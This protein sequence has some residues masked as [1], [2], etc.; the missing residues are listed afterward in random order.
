[1][2][3]D[4]VIGIDSSTTATKAIAW[5]AKGRAVAETRANQ[6]MSNPKPGWF[7]QDVDNWTGALT[8]VLKQLTRKI[9][10]K[11]VAALAISNQRES[12]AQFDARGKTLRP[13]T[14][15]LDERAPAQAA[16]LA[17]KFG[18]E[19]LREISGKPADITP[20]IS[21]CAWFAENMPGLWKKTAMTAEVH[22]VLVHFLTGNWHTSTA[23]ADPMGLIDMARYDWSDELLAAVGLTRAQV[24][25]LFRP[26]EQVGKVTPEA[27]KLTGIKAG[28]PVIA[29]GGDGQCAGTGTNMF[30][31]GR[32]YVNIGTA[33]VSGSSGTTY[34]HAQAFRTLTAVAEEGYI[35]ETC[36]RTGTFLINW[37]VE[38]LFNVDPV[39]NPG[40]FRELER[41]AAAAPIGAGG[42]IVMP[43]WSGSMTPYWDSST[44]GVI[45][46][47][48][49]SHRRGDV[50]RAV[51]EGI[52]LEQ[53]LMTNLASRESQPI[54]HYVAI[55]GGSR[56]DLLCQMLADASARSVKRLDTVE[57]SSLGAA[58]AAAKGAGWFDSIPLAATAMAGKPVKTFRPNRKSSGRY[59]ELLAIYADLYPSVS[60][61]SARLTAFAEGG[62]A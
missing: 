2:P 8:K 59:Q 62:R 49:S 11:R 14:L 36:L 19:R 50:Y 1:M 54:D 4:L 39:K 48:T 13:G 23:S 57:A 56:S 42:I 53:A 15:W 46:G 28:T 47:L 44:R 10:A 61:W 43:H 31:K 30:A 41:E 37:V 35:F 12:F 24:P 20:C 40:I 7:E 25:K 27:A 6:P 45:A 38:N 17:R 33:C 58:I 18:P 26:G 51:L 3:G 60:A 22:G 32:A 34:A 5:N 52:A 9:D 16:A 29:G 21:R 55:G